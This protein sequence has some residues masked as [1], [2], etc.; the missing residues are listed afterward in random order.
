[1]PDAA[2]SDHH[3]PEPWLLRPIIA[4]HIG[5]AFLHEWSHAVALPVQRV[6]LGHCFRAAEAKYYALNRPL[7]E[8]NDA[9]TRQLSNDAESRRESRR[10][11]RENDEASAEA[12]T[13][14]ESPREASGADEEYHPLTFGT[15]HLHEGRG[16]GGKPMSET[17][18]WDLLM[19]EEQTE[20]SDSAMSSSARTTPSP[21]VRCP[22]Q[23]HRVVTNEE[24]KGKSYPK[25][26]MF[27]EC[28]VCETRG[29][30]YRCESG[31]DYDLCQGCYDK[32]AAEI[33]GGRSLSVGW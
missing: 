22:E 17:A 20:E 23:S 30:A 14:D 4:W 1:M 24:V 3:S 18:V 10:E 19:E 25:L 13:A 2:L 16:K 6:T 11:S 29:T 27:G 28:D 33:E 21:C 31:C 26:R 9:V 5:D 8:H 32:A 15:V 12:A 7:K